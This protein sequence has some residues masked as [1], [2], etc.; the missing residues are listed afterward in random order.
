MHLLEISPLRIAEASQGVGVGR[1][2]PNTVIPPRV[3]LESI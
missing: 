1:L 3:V 2:F